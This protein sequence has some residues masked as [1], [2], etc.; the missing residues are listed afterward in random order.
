MIVQTF[1]TQFFLDLG[2]LK[3]ETKH[4]EELSRQLFLESAD[5][6]DAKVSENYI[7]FSSL[8]ILVQ[9]KI[10]KLGGTFDKK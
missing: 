5:L 3:E 8:F 10:E 6:H 9:L 4:A 7:K 1:L 2:P